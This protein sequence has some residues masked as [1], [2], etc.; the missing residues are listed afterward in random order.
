VE[1]KSLEL[2]RS[3]L[4]RKKALRQRGTATPLSVEQE[5]LS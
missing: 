4:E 3:Q 2:K 5:E 1:R